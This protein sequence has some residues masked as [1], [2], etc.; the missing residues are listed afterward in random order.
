MA[1]AVPKE[2]NSVN[3]FIASMKELSSTGESHSACLQDALRERDLVLEELAAMAARGGRSRRRMSRNAIQRLFLLYAPTGPAGWIVRW[4]FF[5]LLITTAAGMGA[6]IPLISH[7]RTSCV[8]L[9][10]LP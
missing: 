10:A 3:A 8:F 2:Q 4:A 9:R 6:L 7:A 5:T 1:L